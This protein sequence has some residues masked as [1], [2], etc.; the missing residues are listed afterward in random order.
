MTTEGDE[1]DGY[2]NGMSI[3][4]AVR[5]R[6]RVNQTRALGLRTM[7]SSHATHGFIDAIRIQ[8][9]VLSGC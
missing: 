9:A 6:S 5:S 4:M 3:G 7:L 8:R 1:I 2:V